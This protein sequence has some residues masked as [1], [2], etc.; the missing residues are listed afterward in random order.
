MFT[1]LLRD[2]GPAPDAGRRGGNEVAH[3]GSV[4]RGRAT[5][6]AQVPEEPDRAYQYD[7]TR[8]AKQTCD[9]R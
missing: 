8:G 1:S 7:Q 6:A 2:L 5:A 4:G 3:I 9:I